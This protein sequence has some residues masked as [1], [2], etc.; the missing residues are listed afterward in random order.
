MQIGVCQTLSSWGSKAAA[1]CALS[2]HCITHLSFRCHVWIPLCAL[3]TPGWEAGRWQGRATDLNVKPALTLLLIT[4]AV[5]LW[6]FFCTDACGLDGTDKFKT[7]KKYFCMCNV[8]SECIQTSAI[9]KFQR[10]S[11]ISI[12]NRACRTQW[13]IQSPSK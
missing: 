7:E 13:K 8:S 5:T 2:S 9:L 10:S 6:I 1:I 12:R 11:N 3:A 4:T